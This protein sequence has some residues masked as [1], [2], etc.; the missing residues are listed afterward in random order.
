[1]A[2]IHCPACNRR[3]SSVAEACP[4][5]HEPL[6]EL[7]AEQR[8][9]LARRRWRTQL[10]RARNLTYLGMGLVVVGALVWWMTPPQ[11]LAVPIGTPAA[12]LLGLGLV[13]YVAS[14][15]WFIWLRYLR[16]PDRPRG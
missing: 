4:H 15:S 11:G 8:S 6:G 10:Y 12:V 9:E 1:M 2:I 5:C 16:N 13:G 7:D 3:I 14:W